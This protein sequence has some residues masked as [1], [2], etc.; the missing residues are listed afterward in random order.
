MSVF[1]PYCGCG[2]DCGCGHDVL[3]GCGGVETRGVAGV[4]A[5]KGSENGDGLTCLQASRSGVDVVGPRHAGCL[6]EAVGSALL[7]P[8]V[9]LIRVWICL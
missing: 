6:L 3:H 5:L 4:S 1:A 7:S 9:F 8:Y 2:Y